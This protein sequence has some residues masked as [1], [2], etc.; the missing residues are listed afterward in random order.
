MHHPV[1]VERCAEFLLEESER[2]LLFYLSLQKISVIP[3][4][5]GLC[6]NGPGSLQMCLPL[7][8]QCCSYQFPF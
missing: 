8:L 6:N 5:V 2:W 3:K 4:I 7:S 1:S